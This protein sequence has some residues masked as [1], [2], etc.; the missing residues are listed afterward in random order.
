[1]ESIVQQAGPFEVFYHVQD[2]GSSDGTLEKLEAWRQRFQEQSGAL[3]CRGVHFSF[4]SESDRGMYDAINRGF[5]ALQVPPHGYMTWLNADDCLYPG[6]LAFVADCL[7]RFPE[8]SLL[9][10][11]SCEMDESGATV[12]I[13]EQQ[14][15][16]DKTL[17][18]GLHDGRRLPFVM[19][20]GAFWRAAA[21]SHCG[22]CRVDL[23]L[24]GDF[25]L[26]RR[27]AAFCS[28]V[29]ADT[30]LGAH[31]VHKGQLS[32]DREAYFGEVEAALAGAPAQERDKEW[33]RFQAWY[34]RSGDSRDSGYDGLVLTYSSAR[35][36]WFLET[37]S[38]DAPPNTTF[39]LNEQGL[40]A[41]VPA[42]FLSGFGSEG[43]LYPRLNLWKGHRAVEAP[44]ALLEFDLPSAG[45]WRIFLRFRNFMDSL[46]I[47]M[48]HGDRVLFKDVAP[49]NR[50]DRDCL[51]EVD[52]ALEKGL[53]TITL[54]LTPPDANAAF[55]FVVHSCEAALRDRPRER[56]GVLSRLF[57]G[58]SR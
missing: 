52:A 43:A 55:G 21:W 56:T 26:W 30:L 17:R 33:Q 8:V 31:R 57:R 39:I 22:G 41:A 3:R 10:G 13:H 29:S 27:M 36:C 58:L 24:A 28:F 1:V 53:N 18:A 54:H 40:T 15:Y 12:R 6:A 51:L 11:R 9:G 5:A 34:G 47:A 7:E 42:R 2:G 50:H 19:Q 23:R 37:R 14:V 49:L 25:D 45:V 38:P 16:A 4:S 35:K 44:T 46:Q 20:E 48:M 32:G